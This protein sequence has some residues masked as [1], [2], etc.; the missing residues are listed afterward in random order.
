MIDESSVSGLFD[1]RLFLDTVAWGRQLRSHLAQVAGPVP[2][3]S[4]EDAAGELEAHYATPPR[5]YH[6][7]GHALE[8]ARLVQVLSQSIPEGPE[9]QDLPALIVAALCHDAVYERGNSDNE[10]RSAEVARGIA[11]A[12]RLAADSTEL[13]AHLVLATAHPPR[14]PASIDEAVIRDA[15]LAILAAPPARY[16]DYAAAIRAEASAFDDTEFREAR[17]RF[18]AGFLARDRLFYCEGWAPLLERRARGNL[19][20]EA[21][22]LES[23]VGKNAPESGL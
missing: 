5:A 1:S 3:R 23:K 18:L 11:G 16:D 2:E 7:L 9:P 14:P 12:L 13:A 21:A 15:D 20:A 22:L 6:T 19:A 10:E 17:G 4:L 8:V